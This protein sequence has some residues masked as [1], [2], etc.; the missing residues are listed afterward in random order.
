MRYFFPEKKK[1]DK[2]T[3]NYF[4]HLNMGVTAIFVWR[5]R[6]G[7]NEKTWLQNTLK[8]LKNILKVFYVIVK[9]FFV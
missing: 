3:N 5:D 4:F 8:L 9:R 2:N 6:R 1:K 7:G